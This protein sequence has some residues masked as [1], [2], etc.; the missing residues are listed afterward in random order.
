MVN[1]HDVRP[2][3]FP[4][5]EVVYRGEFYSI[6]FG[7]WEGAYNVLAMRFDGDGQEI[8]FPNQAGHPLWCVLPDYLYQ[9]VLA[10]LALYWQ[11]EGFDR[12]AW[13]NAASA[14][15]ERP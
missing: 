10:Q 15:M 3:K 12:Q 14:L 7:E 6:A 5:P 13:E 11:E 9:A 4:N 1:P 2:G 8:G